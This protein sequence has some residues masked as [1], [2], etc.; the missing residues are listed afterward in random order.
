MI[1]LYLTKRDKKDVKLVTLLQGTCPTPMKLTDLSALDL[2]AAWTKTLE[3]I[4]ASERTHYDL[5]MESASDVLELQRR[6]RGRGY[7]QIPIMTSPMVWLSAVPTGAKIEENDRFLKGNYA[8]EISPLAL[9]KMH[10]AHER[11]R[12]VTP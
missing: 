12:R 5:W 10:L 7:K 6:L 4:A 11:L 8:P 2:P 9:K 1:Y 3:G